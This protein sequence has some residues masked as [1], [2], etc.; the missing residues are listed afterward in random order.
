MSRSDGVS[1]IAG[2]GG[3]LQREI[4]SFLP[5]RTKECLLCVGFA[6]NTFWHIEMGWSR[7]EE[8]PTVTGF[9][10]MSKLFFSVLLSFGITTLHLTGTVKYNESGRGWQGVAGELPRQKPSS[11][12]LNWNISTTSDT[13]NLYITSFHSWNKVDCFLEYAEP[14]ARQC[15]LAAIVWLSF[16]VVPSVGVTDSKIL[17]GKFQPISLQFIPGFWCQ[18]IWLAEKRFVLPAVFAFLQFLQ[19][20]RWCD[21]LDW[22]GLK[23]HCQSA[24]MFFTLHITAPQLHC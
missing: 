2:H 8:S 20:V 16:T 13:D 11:F 10:G 9:L 24:A 18:V 6:S 12:F 22:A 14:G 19:W 15:Y 21:L 7:Q 3:G 5:E 23:E 17:S 1:S 4:V